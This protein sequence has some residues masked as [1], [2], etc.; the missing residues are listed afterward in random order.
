MNQPTALVVDD[1]PDICEL[2]ELTLL[3]MGIACHTAAS[4]TEARAVLQK[5]SDID[6]CLTDMKLP[7]GNGIDLVQFIQEH[8]PAIPSA[9]ITA[10]GNME[11]AVLA[12]KA[13]AFDFVSKPVDLGI[14]RSLVTT[15]LKL[16]PKDQQIKPE[17]ALTLLGNSPEI[18]H[19]RTTIE[20]LARS[21]APV[22]INGES[23]TG[24]ELAARLIHE[25]GARADKLFVPV[26]CGAIPEAL[27]ESE[28]F[29]HVK[30]SF[31]GASANKDGLFQAA[32]GG[33]LFLDEVADL[34]L[35]MQV[36]LLRAIQEKA[37]RPVGA[38]QEIKVDVR[39]LSATHKDLAQQVK[40]GKFR[41]DLFYRIN[42]IEL[43]IPALRERTADVPQLITHIL[44]KL[45][46]DTAGDAPS[47]DNE[48]LK[49]LLRYTFPGNIRE[50]E[51]I[52]E[53]AMTLCENNHILPA[54]LQLDQTPVTSQ[55]EQP[56]Q[57][58]V[59]PPSGNQHT[60]LDPLL[61]GIEKENIIKALE[62]T[63]Y[64]KT[65]AAK[66]LGISFG[67]L[68]YRIKKLGL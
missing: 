27:V 40:E 37:V 18:Q 13:G 67:A 6:L 47:I 36:K 54:D 8:H 58:N 49:A 16:N 26:N 17:A 2:L 31:T 22:H 20:K 28:F 24:K 55:P 68:R 7:D 29:G 43:H 60:P 32:D 9:V 5:H 46:H 65:A 61:G 14:L 66:L 48:T 64:N 57:T 50:L 11:S 30:G 19:T 39:I 15:A 62:Q 53:R 34:P 38:H 35:H 59:T 4:I 12:L 42:V 52:L 63:H 10:H 3:R 25:Q 33:T 41:Q 56:N 51:N 21:Q 23:G 1:E 44:G 45:T